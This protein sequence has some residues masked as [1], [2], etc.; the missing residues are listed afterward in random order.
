MKP[1]SVDLPNLSAHF[2]AQAVAC[3]RLGSPFTA[4]LCRLLPGLCDDTTTTGRR[5]LGWSGDPRADALALRLCGGLHRLVLEKADPEFVAAYPPHETDDP[6]L[7]A[8]VATV[9]RRHD[10]ALSAALDSAPQTNEIAR[11]AMLLPGFLMLARATGLPLALC[12]IGASGG[13]NLLFDRFFYRYGTQHW[14]AHAS[15][16]EIRPELRS[17]SLP[18]EGCLKIVSRQGCDITPVDVSQSEGQMRLRSYVWADQVARLERLNGAIAL[19]QD[20]PY[21]LKRADAGAFVV[22]ALA[23]RPKDAACVLFHSIMWQYMP[24]ATQNAILR[25]LQ[26][27]GLRSTSAAPIAHLCMEPLDPN[28]SFATLSLTIWPGGETQ[29]LAKCDFHGRWIEWIA[30]RSVAI[31]P[32]SLPARGA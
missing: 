18:L 31:Q 17:P 9:L 6:A 21:T 24:G 16:V 12:E 29:H 4:R 10:A 1:T 3:E 2:E 23:N 30:W 27:E 22:Q 15:A 25:A 7:S 32:V 8:S 20:F 14:G 13:L 5:V 11:S 19:A 28:D 26:K